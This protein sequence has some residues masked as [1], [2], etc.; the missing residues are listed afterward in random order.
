M[1]FVL[2]TG[3]TG[4]VARGVL[5]YLSATCIPRTPSPCRPETKSRSPPLQRSAGTS[6]K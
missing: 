3:A 2:V 4:E 6:R 1:S 5:P